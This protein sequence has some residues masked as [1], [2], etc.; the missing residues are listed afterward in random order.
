MY[1]FQKACKKCGHAP[2]ARSKRNWKDKIK[3]GLIPYYRH[4]HKLV[5]TSCGHK[6]WYKIENM[7]D[8]LIY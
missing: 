7:E 4:R 3:T 6:S 5:C 1:Q 8:E 2:L